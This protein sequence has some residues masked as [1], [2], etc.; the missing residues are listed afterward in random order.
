MDI[1]SA[2]KS[3]SPSRN[4]GVPSHDLYSAEQSQ[5]HSTYSPSEYTAGTYLQ[6]SQKQSKK[7][8]CL[9]FLG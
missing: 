1:N 6:D 7:R 9:E 8:Y 5:F 2:I 4:M 3:L